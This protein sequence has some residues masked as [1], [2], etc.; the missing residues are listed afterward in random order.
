M[1]LAP[2]EQLSEYGLHSPGV[3]QVCHICGNLWRLPVGDIGGID[4]AEGRPAAMMSLV[5]SGM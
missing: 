1:N 2:S 4:I 5:S 3:Q